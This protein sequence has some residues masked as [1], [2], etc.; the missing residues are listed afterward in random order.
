MYIPQYL[1]ERTFFRKQYLA[2]YILNRLEEQIAKKLK[3]TVVA[4]MPQNL[5][6]YMYNVIT[7]I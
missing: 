3:K 7:I 2:W 5:W 6:K 4:D 1:Q